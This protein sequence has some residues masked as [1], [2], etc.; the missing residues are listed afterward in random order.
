MH[1]DNKKVNEQRITALLNHSDIRNILITTIAELSGFSL[2][3]THEA[4]VT[5]NTQHSI[6]K[7]EI[8]AKVTLVKS[9][10]DD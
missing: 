3:S 8:E 10:Q 2:D 7:T 9:L 6:D 5:F 4:Y 1:I